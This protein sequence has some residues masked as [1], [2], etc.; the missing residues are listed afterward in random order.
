MMFYMYLE[1]YKKVSLNCEILEHSLI[2]DIDISFEHIQIVNSCQDKR[3]GVQQC[4][5]IIL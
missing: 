1:Y 4:T 2:I 3:S 5:V